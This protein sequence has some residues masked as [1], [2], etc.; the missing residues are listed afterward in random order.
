M[1][2]S[3]V[4]STRIAPDVGSYIF[5][6]SFTSVVLPAPFS[7]TMATTAPA[8][9]VERHVVEHEPRRCR[10]RRT[11]RARSRMPSR[12]RAG[13]GLIGRGDERR[14]VVLEPGQPPRAVQPDAAQEADLAD[15]RADVRRQPRAR[16][17]HEQHVAGGRVEAR[18]RRTRPRRR[19]RRRRSPTPA[20]A[21]RAEP[22]RAAATGPYQRSHAARRSVDQ[23]LA[24]AG[25]AHLLA[26]RRGR[27]EREQVAGQ[28]VATGAPRS[29]AA[30]STAGPPRRREHRRQREHGEQRRA[31]DG[32]TSSSAIVTPSRRIQPQ[33][34]N[35]DMYMWSSTK[36]WSRSIDE[37]VEVLGPLVVRDGRD[38]R[39]Q[40][41]DV[42]LERDRHLVAEAAL[43]ARADTCAGTR[44]P[45]PTRRGRRPRRSTSRAVAARARR[46]RA[47]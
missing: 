39:L 9:S 33:V 16:R 17:E 11:T 7:P 42:R 22:Q 4:S 36:T 32:S 30:R 25:D 35:S 6:S 14:G 13:T 12:S 5:A 15:R 47:A 43:H 28:P 45:W 41:R 46:R 27:R 44:S 34:E 40:P 10:G 26:G 8:G 1:R 3:G 18:R 19:T 31:P 20:C 23:P 29:C 24:D 21:R 38:R 37:P 2:A